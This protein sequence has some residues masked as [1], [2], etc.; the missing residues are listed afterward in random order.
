MNLKEYKTKFEDINSMIDFIETENEQENE[1]INE[2]YEMNCL[3]LKKKIEKIDDVLNKK[4][5]LKQSLMM[6]LRVPLNH[7]IIQ[8]ILE[9]KNHLLI[10]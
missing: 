8:V 4:Q 10:G 3:L 9:L 7:M 6:F 2:K 5:Q 1:T